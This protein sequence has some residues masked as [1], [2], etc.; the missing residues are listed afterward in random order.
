MTRVRDLTYAHPVVVL[1]GGGHWEHVGGRATS[2]LTAD[3]MSAFIRYEDAVATRYGYLVTSWVT[4]N[5]G[6]LYA[7]VL[8]YGVDDGASG[9]PPTQHPSNDRRFREVA[10]ASA[11][12]EVADARRLAGA[13]QAARPLLWA[14]R[15]EEPLVPVA[16][17]E[18]TAW[19][20][21]TIR[22]AGLLPIGT[23]LL[24]AAQEAAEGI[25]RSSVPVDVA[26][27]GYTH[28]TREKVARKVAA[29]RATPVAVLR[30]GTLEQFAN[31]RGPGEY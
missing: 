28:P 16:V 1:D 15:G 6:A 29:G 31:D 30:I 9:S 2:P 19:S 8:V 24:L 22:S 23:D 7:G 10:E 25:E 21:V 18:T 27:Y 17:T 4:T 26:V 20:R 3:G 5:E 12:P 13:G 11:T 14:R